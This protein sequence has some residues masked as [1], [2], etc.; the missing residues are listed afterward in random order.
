M[1]PLQQHISLCCSRSWLSPSYQ[2]CLLWSFWDTTSGVCNITNS[3]FS[4][5][6]IPWPISLDENHFHFRNLH[7]ADDAPTKAA[8]SYISPFFVVVLGAAVTVT[9]GAFFILGVTSRVPYLRRRL[10]TPPI[11]YIISQCSRSFGDAFLVL[12]C[13]INPRNIKHVCWTFV[14]IFVLLFRPAMH[15]SHVL[16]G[17]W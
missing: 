3:M 14:H 11:Q 9:Y 8:L 17:H 7:Q 13:L 4:L 15:Q 1:S 6:S 16:G 5:K 12:V 2:L 10:I